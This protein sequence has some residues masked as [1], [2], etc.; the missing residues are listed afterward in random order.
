MLHQAE[1][2]SVLNAKLQIG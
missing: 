2:V 1:K